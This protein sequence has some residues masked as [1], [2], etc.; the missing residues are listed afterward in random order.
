MNTPKRSVGRRLVAALGAAA[1]G[2][3]GAAGIASADPTAPPNPSY[4]N[5]DTA[6]K[7]TLDI[8]KLIG[9]QSVIS[10]DGTVPTPSPSGT[11]VKDVEF[12]VTQV[13]LWTGGT[14]VALALGTDS[15]AWSKVPTGTNP[16]AP[17]DTATEGR[18][19]A[20]STTETVAKTDANGLAEFSDLALGLYYVEETDA[21][22]NI[23]SQTVPFYVTI[24]LPNNGQWLY[25]VNVYP[26]N[27]ELNAPTKTI[28]DRPNN[29]VVGATVTWT[30]SATV[31]ALNKG[32]TYDSVSIY[33]NLP[34]YLTD[35]SSTVKVN[36]AIVAGTNDVTF[37]NNNGALT[38]VW[39]DPRSLNA[40][41]AI[42]I[43][44]TT[45]VKS[46][47][48][49]GGIPNDE[50]GITVNRTTVPGTDIPYTYWGD[51]KVNKTD[52][53]TP[54][55]ALKGAEFQVFEKGTGDCPATPP[56]SS[57]VAT[58]TS[59]DN[60]A[61]T[62]GE[63]HSTTL[64]LWVANSD[65]AV[66]SPAKDY[67]LYETKVPAGYTGAG[68]ETVTITPGSDSV[69]TVTAVNSQKTGPQL[70]LTGANGQLLALIGGGSLV[71]LAAG[72][73]LVARKRSHQD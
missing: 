16:A 72:T 70:P 45:T 46:I 33:D 11:A 28:A 27:Q 51:L 38:W 7:G 26:K 56:S 6:Q 17:L 20:V 1:L 66:T 48:T 61:V 58:G 32:E 37:T 71:L 49:Q 62:W 14:C 10:G 68:V 43:E 25:T 52:N 42:T 4:G 47:P 44:L 18:L 3:V 30:I 13:G 55:K 57:E 15:D 2:L 19:C 41:D 9:P 21:P 34:T 5:I 69:K 29:L 22:S 50:Y 73:A 63:T 54:A 36:G 53:S 35:P 59:G 60:G 23:V 40:N 65:T 12:T 64:T 39:N 8:H 24:P 67:C 31:P